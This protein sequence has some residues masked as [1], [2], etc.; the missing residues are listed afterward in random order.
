[1][2]TDIDDRVTSPAR[3]SVTR[4]LI[5]YG[6]VACALP[7]LALK[8]VWIAGGQVGVADPAIMREPT[9]V[10]LNVVTAVMDVVAIAMALAFTHQWGLRIPAWLLLPP[11][12]VATGLLSRFVIAVP[13]VMVVQA[14]TRE[15]TRAPVGGPVQPWVYLVVYSG[16]TGMGIGLVLAFALYASARWAAVFSDQNR[17]PNLGP[18]RA[19]LGLV[20]NV[21]A[22]LAA[23]SSALFLAWA[24]GATIGLRADLVAGRT[25]SSY[26]LNAIDAAMGFAAAAGILIMAHGRGRLTGHWIVVSLTWVGSGSL[27]AWG[28]WHLINVL[29]DTALVRE[30]AQGM[31]VVNLMSLVRLIA[32]LL[33]GL[34]SLVLMG[35]RTDAEGGRHRA[36]MGRM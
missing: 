22:L 31:A 9:M 11:M 13:A 15:S 34:V 20:A 24:L 30:R 35:A 21:A 27:F 12:W 1:M 6:V 32:G 36:D 10:T 2:R 16:F 14:F 26:L 23:A 33:I 25:F 17:G 4:L 8:I 28:L 3:S 7:Y 5:G 18:A 19:A 29:G